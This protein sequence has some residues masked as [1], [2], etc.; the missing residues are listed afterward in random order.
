[1][2]GSQGYRGE[3][4]LLQLYHEEHYPGHFQHHPGTGASFNNTYD[5]AGR[6]ME[7]ETVWNLDRN[8]RLSGHCSYQ[9]SA[10]QIARQGAGYASP[11]TYRRAGWRIANGRPYFA[12]VR[13]LFNAEAHEPSLAPCAAYFQVIDKF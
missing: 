9:D 8:L 12:V 1:V 4:E 2:A 3:S 10:D 6:K 7:L 5:Q 11:H 13:N